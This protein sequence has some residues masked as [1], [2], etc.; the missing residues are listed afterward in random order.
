M[1]KKEVRKWIANNSE[2][3]VHYEFSHINCNYALERG[4]GTTRHQCWD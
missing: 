3:I 2:L 1:E 4:M